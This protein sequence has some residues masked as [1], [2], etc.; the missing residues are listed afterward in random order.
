MT[1][2]NHSTPLVSAGAYPQAMIPLRIEGGD[3]TN[4]ALDTF[5]QVAL[6]T[7]ISAAACGSVAGQAVSVDLFVNLGA[8]ALPIA[9]TAFLTGGYLVSGIG[10]GSYV[11][12]SLATATLASSCPRFCAADST[13]RYFRL[14]A[15]NGMISVSQGGALGGTNNDQPAT[16]GAINYARTIGC[17]QLL[18]D[19]DT[20]SIWNT[21]RT[22]AAAQGGTDPDAQDG[23]SI[24]VTGS[25][26][27][28]GLSTITRIKMLS[29]TGTSLETGWQNVAGNVW[30]GSG[31]NLIGGAYYGNPAANNLAFFGM[32][33]IWLDGGCAYTGVRTAVTPSSP[34]G[35]DLTN[36][37]IRLQGTRCDAITLINC[38]ISGF[39]GEACY[40]AGTTQT[41][42]VLKNTTISGSNQSCFNPSVG[43]VHA[44]NCE[45]GGGNAAMEVL[46]GIGGRFTNCRFFNCLQISITGGPANGLLYNY[47]YPTRNLNTAPPW[48]DFI[49][50]EFTNCGTLICGNYLR[51]KTARI[52]DTFIVVNTAITNG[53]LTSTYIDGDYT[54]DQMTAAPLVVFQ[55]PANTTTPIPGYNPNNVMIVP[56]NDFHIKLNIHRTAN[57]ISNGFFAIAYSSSGL[58]DQNSCSFAL[59][60]ADGVLLIHSPNYGGGTTLSQP[61]IT[62]DGPTSAQSVAGSGLPFAA[63]PLVLSNSPYAITIS[64]PAHALW[65]TG[66]ASTIICTLAAPFTAPAGF[67]NGQKSRI[68]WHPQSTPAT[69]YSFAHNGTGLRLNSDCTLAVLGDSIEVEFNVSTA[70][71]HETGRS[72]H[73]A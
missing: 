59:G 70:R 10:G 22:S 63:Y 66:A 15:Q 2:W 50:C 4:P 8:H 26:K 65:N 30:R 43:S 31:I 36:K 18:F 62:C 42:Q 56:P 3:P 49:G 28:L 14:A 47:G 41:A 7:V 20:V 40:I 24:W 37:G 69:T 58:L 35:P 23:Q 19:F 61:M 45:F 32:E 57:A 51:I 44:D 72:I 46:G 71:W 48:V 16:Q 1:D 53:S 73:A 12:D 68:F 52:T 39:K 25:I 13:G 21:V 11:A 34:D 38:T 54:I 9:T 60:D 33:N 27:F 29:S 6:A 64:N 67:A 5:Q 55:G 17:R